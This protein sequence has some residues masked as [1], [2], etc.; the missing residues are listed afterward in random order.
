[1]ASNEASKRFP[2][3]VPEILDSAQKEVHNYLANEIGQYFQGIFT[4][5]DSKTDALIGPYTHFLYLPQP[6]ASGYFINGSS[7][8]KIP[9]FPL[10]CREIAIL[11]IGEHYNAAYELYSHVRIAKKVGLRDEQIEDILRGK[12][13]TGGTE[14][15]LVSWEVARALMTVKGPLSED[16]WGRAE[17]AFGK[18]GAGALIHY[19]GFY[20]YTCVLL[21]GAAVSVPEGESIWPITA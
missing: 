21:N 20:A 11:A 15:E 16:L 18:A 1:M 9:D 3:I 13:P 7:L 2:P 8:S 10:R 6:V 19:S 5:Q 17:K 12:C 14:Q 4:I